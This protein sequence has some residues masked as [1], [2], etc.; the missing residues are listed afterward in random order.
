MLESFYD[1]MI[2]VAGISVVAVRV[3][4]LREE[5]VALLDKILY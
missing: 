4:S 3:W 5:G 1:M 2:L